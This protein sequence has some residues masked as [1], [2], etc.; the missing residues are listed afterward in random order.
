MSRLVTRQLPGNH[1]PATAPSWSFVDR[2]I[3]IYKN[4]HDVW[5]RNDFLWECV[6]HKTEGPRPGSGASFSCQKECNQTY[7]THHQ[8]S[9][10]LSVIK[11]CLLNFPQTGSIK[12]P[13]RKWIIVPILASKSSQFSPHTSNLQVQWILLS[14]GGSQSSGGTAD[15]F[16]TK[17][18]EV[19][20]QKNN[21]HVFLV[22]ENSKRNF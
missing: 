9:K 16:W 20:L 3:Y 22:G 17:Q 14:V 4:V 6:S 19:Q 7:A 2:Y 11:W 10:K 15:E 18:A 21:S 5:S 13:I 1:D 8:T 12:N